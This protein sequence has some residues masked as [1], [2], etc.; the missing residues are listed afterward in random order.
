MMKDKIIPFPTITSISSS[1]PITQQPINSTFNSF[2]MDSISKSEKHKNNKKRVNKNPQNLKI[3]PLKRKRRITTENI[4]GDLPSNIRR[5][6]SSWDLMR[7]LVK[8]VSFIQR[9]EVF[10]IK[11][12]VIIKLFFYFF[13]LMNNN[14]LMKKSEE[15]LIVVK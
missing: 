10:F 6:R 4:K 7:N 12:Q 13:F 14:N 1:Q 8:G 3:I 9:P 11:D 15:Y 2:E 5:K